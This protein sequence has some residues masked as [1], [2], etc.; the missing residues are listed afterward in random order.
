M[1]KENI[2]PLPLVFLQNRIKKQLE[3]RR[4][5]TMIW[6]AAKKKANNYPKYIAGLTHADY[7]SGDQIAGC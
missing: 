1:L 3:L 7:E 4:W 5:Q 2:I 6:V